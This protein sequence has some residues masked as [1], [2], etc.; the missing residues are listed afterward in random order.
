MHV[1]KVFCPEAGPSFDMHYQGS[2]STYLSLLDKRKEWGSMSSPFHIE[3]VALWEYLPLHTQ[4]QECCKYNYYS[5]S[6]Q[7]WSLNKCA[8][9][10]RNIEEVGH[11]IKVSNHSATR[12]VR[13]WQKPNHGH[14]LLSV[15]METTPSCQTGTCKIRWTGDYFVMTCSPL[16]PQP[17]VT[18]QTARSPISTGNIGKWLS[19]IIFGWKRYIYSSASHYILLIFLHCFTCQNFEFIA[20]YQRLSDAITVQN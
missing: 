3:P 18:I 12:L 2:R 17:P 14:C 8:S 13:F 11:K 19:D 6:T 10:E 5:S 4:T 20:S 1:C 16:T 9:E 15:A 7:R